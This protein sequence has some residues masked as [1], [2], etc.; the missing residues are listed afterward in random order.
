MPINK[1]HGGEAKSEPR[2]SFPKT[3]LVLV[4]LLKVHS[5]AFSYEHGSVEQGIQRTVALIHR[6]RAS[7]VPVVLVTM[8]RS[9]ELLPEITAA[10][11]PEGKTFPKHKMSAFSN[12]AF[13]AYLASEGID[14][15]I[16]GGWIRHLCVMATAV[17]AMDK[18]YSVMTSDEIMFGV[19]DILSVRVRDMAL[20]YFQRSGCLYEDSQ[21]IWDAV[22][23]LRG[24]MS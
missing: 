22:G 21:G 5:Q 19:T 1:N 20:G 24:K 13:E 16:V 8:A 15:L 9:R 2:K 17:D 12:P 14:S 11:G 10:A 23:H 6:C 7:C 4:D 18:G 3:A